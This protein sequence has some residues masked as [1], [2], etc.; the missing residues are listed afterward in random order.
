VK[1][2][3]ENCNELSGQTSTWND[4]SKGDLIS[5]SRSFLL[6]YLLARLGN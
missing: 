5:W 3:D 2:L 4:K 1:K 6:L